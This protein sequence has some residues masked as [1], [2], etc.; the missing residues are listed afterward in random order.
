MKNKVK[1]LGEICMAV[2]DN[3]DKILTFDGAL[4]YIKRK[5]YEYDIVEFSFEDQPYRLEIKYTLTSQKTLL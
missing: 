2:R 5:Y 4:H 1:K 3:G